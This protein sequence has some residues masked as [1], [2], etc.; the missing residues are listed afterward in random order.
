M[1]S[2]M[3]AA[4]GLGALA[5]T[6]I[7]GALVPRRLSRRDAG[8][9]NDVYL[10][11]MNAAHVDIALPANPEV[12]RRLAFLQDVGIRTDHPR[13]SHILVGWGGRDFYPDTY[14][15]WRISPMGLLESV[16]GD[17][18]VLRFDPAA[19][20]GGSWETRRRIPLSDQGLSALID[21]ILDTLERNPDGSFRP[22]DHFGIN[23]TDHFYKARPIFTAFAGCNVWASRALAAA[24][25]PSG[26]WTPLPQPLIASL[27]WHRWASGNKCER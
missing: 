13:M 11:L 6:L 10:D 12:R 16:F 9:R 26:I 7:F 17:E 22:L 5:G 20:L 1:S 21:F 3:R 25:V 27:W 18:S 24:G 19:D 2:W 14:R 23:E 15:P 4:L 8:G